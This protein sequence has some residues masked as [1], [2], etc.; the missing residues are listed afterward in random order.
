MSR[1][2]RP[3]KQEHEKLGA[4]VQARVTVA[5]HEHIRRVAADAGVTVSDYL[6]RR[7]CSYQVPA[8]ARQRATD[9]AL[10]TE[11]N[12]LGVELKAVGN[13][14]NQIAVAAHTGRRSRVEWEAVVSQIEGAV[15]AV[16]DVLE[17]MVSGDAF[18]IGTSDESE[19]GDG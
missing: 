14:A 10:V 17:R 8:G 19:G 12:K 11:A 13:L 15:G 3:E 1:M 4:V 9:P 18:E 2:G 6:R 16:H 5:E 7:A